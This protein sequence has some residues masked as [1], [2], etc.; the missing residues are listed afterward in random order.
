MYSFVAASILLFRN[1][2]A[3]L[4]RVWGSEDTGTVCTPL[5]E[6]CGSSS[7]H[8]GRP[9]GMMTVSGG[10]SIIGSEEG[11]GAGGWGLG[12]SEPGEAGSGFGGCCSVLPSPLAGEGT[13]VRGSA[14][15]EPAAGAEDGSG[16]IESASAV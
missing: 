6:I 15:D 11:V 7:T 13:G 1:L 4:W 2:I 9:A 12:G 16:A 8:F 10:A 14:A 3:S 5:P